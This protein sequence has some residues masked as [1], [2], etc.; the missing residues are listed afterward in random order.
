[1]EITVNAK[2]CLLIGAITI[3]SFLSPST[4]EAG[5]YTRWHQR[6]NYCYSYYYYTPVRYH[7]VVYYPSRPRYYYYYNPYRKVYWGRFD[8][9]GTPGQ[10][11]SLLA[12]E[13]RRANLDD[14]PE[15][16]FP[17]PGPMPAEPEAN[18]GANLAIPPAPPEATGEA[19]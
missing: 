8:S 10:Q 16:A 19:R 15:S 6:G 18:D 7:H 9:E 17:P 13:D 12:P 1:M 14:I 2:K 5:H 3:G 4:G 11:Y